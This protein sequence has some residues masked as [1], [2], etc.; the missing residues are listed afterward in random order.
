MALVCHRLRQILAGL[1]QLRG[2]SIKPHISV[3]LIWLPE[4][5]VYDLNGAASY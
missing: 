1:R 4:V 5:V 3:P 2:L